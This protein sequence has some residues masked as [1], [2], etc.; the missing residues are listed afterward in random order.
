MAVHLTAHT[1]I[2]AKKERSPNFAGKR[3][4]VERKHTACFSVKAEQLNWADGI[5]CVHNEELSCTLH[6]MNRTV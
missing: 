4:T 3:E 5:H 1:S 6:L 2:T